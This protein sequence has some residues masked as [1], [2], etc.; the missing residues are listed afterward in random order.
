MIGDADEPPMN[1]RSAKRPPAPAD[2]PRSF[3]ARAFVRGQG[4]GAPDGR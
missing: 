2:G 3:H 4:G 1:G